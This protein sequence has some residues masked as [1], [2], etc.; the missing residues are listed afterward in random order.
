MSVLGEMGMLGALSH[1]HERQKNLTVR[2]KNRSICILKGAG[3]DMIDA[4]AVIGAYRR[5]RIGRFG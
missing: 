3:A 5:G 1:E 2:A 4:D